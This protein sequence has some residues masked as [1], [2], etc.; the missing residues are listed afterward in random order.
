MSR[1]IELHFTT[2]FH[3][4]RSIEVNSEKY[5]EIAKY[6]KIID[7]SSLWMAP[8]EKSD[9]ILKPINETLVMLPWNVSTSRVLCDIYSPIGKLEEYGKEIECEYS[10]R[11]ILKKNF[12]KLN[13]IGYIL[14]ASAEMEFFIMK[15]KNPIDNAGYLSPSPI[16]KSAKIREEIYNALSIFQIGVEYLHHEVSKG[17][18]EIC[19]N[20]D[21]AI[22]MA[23]KIQTFK[24]I[25]KNII[26]SH[27]LEITFMPKPFKD[28]NGNGM[29][30][31]LSLS[32]FN[33]KNVFYEKG[34][35]LSKIAKNF[36]GG[37][38][39]HA[40]SLAALAAPTINSYK[41]L[42][43][44]Y[45]APINICWGPINRSVLIRIPYFFNEKSSRIE[46]RMPDPCCNP[47]LTLAGIIA[48]GI[49]GIEKEK[50]PGEPIYENVYKKDGIYENLPKNLNEAL[51]ELNK[52]NVLRNAFNSNVLDKYI[53][54]KKKEWNEYMK[55]YE[56]WNPYEITEWEKN[57]YFNFI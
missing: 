27:N 22:N 31:H 51:D 47:Y 48:I 41:R 19:L 28:M 44:G 29:H 18:S 3:G 32:N 46:L 20:Y 25:S 36:I 34:S 57:K 26:E 52:D 40:K 14:N 54:I 53:E 16:D 21:N 39:E 13:E 10:P 9:L 1:K 11:Y 55:I 15:D 42:L 30:I 7:G 5:E 6:G 4:L 45:E 35:T 37:I 24:Y 43:P 33:G 23:D 2:L 12:K 17:Q 8:I 56:E 50:D 49:D 38:L